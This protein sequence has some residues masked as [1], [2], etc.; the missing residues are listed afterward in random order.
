MYLDEGKPMPGRQSRRTV[1]KSSGDFR[2]DGLF[3]TCPRVMNRCCPYSCATMGALR[4]KFFARLHA[5]FFS[6]AAPVGPSSGNSLDELF[7]PGN[8]LSACRC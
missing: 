3:Q 7:G 5:M 6:G 1:R 4:K 8:R 2:P